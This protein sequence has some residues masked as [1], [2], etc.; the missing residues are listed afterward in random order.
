MFKILEAV[1]GQQEGFVFLTV[2]KKGAWKEKLFSYPADVEKIKDYL[3][4]PKEG[5]DIYW[6]PL[7]FSKPQRIKKNALT[8]SNILWADLDEVDPRKLEDL[9]PSIAWASSEDRYQAIW[10]LDT[11]YDV[12]DV[13]NVNRDLTYHIGADKGGWDITQVLRIPGTK[14]YKYSPPQEGKLLW[15]KKHEHS[16]SELASHV[17]GSYSEAVEAPTSGTFIPDMLKDWSLPRRIIDLLTIDPKEVVV[18][19]RS[20][21]LWEIET[22]LVEAGL[23][24]LSIISIVKACPWNKFIGRRDADEQIYKEVLKAEAHVKIRGKTTIEP[25][26]KSI[27]LPWAVP[28]EDFVGKRT[29][30]PTWLIDGIWQAGS[31]GMIAGEP[32]TYKSVLATDLALSVASGKPFL[33]VFETLKRGAVLYVQ[34]E[35][36]EQT[37]QDRIHKIAHHKG[38]MSVTASGFPVIEPLPIYFSNNYGIDLTSPE[39]RELLEKTM[40]SIS[41]VV[42]ILDP[43]YMM[44]GKAE[45][46]SATEI[47]DILR[48]L[49]YI[50]NTYGCA[51]IICHH[52]G[53]P[54]SG[55]PSGKG[56]NK[57]RGTSEFHAWVESA[58]YI[59]TTP[60]VTTIEVERE[61]RAF[62]AVPQFSVKMELGEPGE[63]FYRPIVKD[64]SFSEELEVKKED[65]ITWIYGGART[66]EELRILT[67]L[68][69][70]DLTRVLDELVED[71]YVIKDAGIGRG[72]KT[73][74]VT[75]MKER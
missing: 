52:Y 45:E 61:F 44:L 35:N 19:S 74:Y 51:I 46:N 73:T 58:L 21:R 1:W 26:A 62:P 17:K 22:A 32:K 41:P 47:R 69:K 55:K 29:G 18:G 6:C 5:V 59:K 33:G 56:G 66:Y 8:T 54:Q 20:D 11:A 40:E 12:S 13:E 50:R 43:L 24:V 71:G 23:P 67:R 42:V 2:K 16:F 25:L 31:Y 63:M 15:A 36:S 7:V 65:V 39:S 64:F 3:A 28:Y 14:N 72:K 57:I 70:R 34:E 53:K 38:L 9:T 48:W 37:V 27:D 49:T 60:E 10:F 30:R 75:T 4:S 68:T